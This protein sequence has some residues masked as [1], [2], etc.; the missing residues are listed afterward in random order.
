MTPET[1]RMFMFFLL[2]H[3]IAYRHHTTYCTKGHAVTENEGNRFSN[4]GDTKRSTE[5]AIIMV[6]SVDQVNT[7]CH[8]MAHSQS[9]FLG[10][11]LGY[12]IDELGQAVIIGLIGTHAIGHGTS[13][14][15]ISVP[16]FTIVDSTEW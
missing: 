16:I 13:G 14:R 15:L 3:S 6:T 9:H 10:P 12:L 1:I 2:S 4:D 7:P 8:C 5:I 11:F